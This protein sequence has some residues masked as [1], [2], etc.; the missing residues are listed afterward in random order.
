MRSSLP[1]QWAVRPYAPDYGIDGSIE[2]FGEPNTDGEAETLGELFLF[3]LRSRVSCGIRT[4]RVRGRMNIEK[5][6]LTPTAMGDATIE[7]IPFRIR[8]DDLMTFEGMGTGTAV[9]LFLV[10]LDSQ[11]VF[12]VCLTDLIEKVTTPEDPNWL[13][14]SLEK[15]CETL[16]RWFPPHPP[17]PRDHQAEKSTGEHGHGSTIET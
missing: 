3:Q 10:C 17:G 12:F 6:P 2:V 8:T 4:L 9:V 13:Y 15:V 5:Y 1:K 14:S 16:L 7:V 11:R